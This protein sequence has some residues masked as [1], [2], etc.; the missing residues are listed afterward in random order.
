MA[1]GLAEVDKV[2]ELQLVVMGVMTGV[3]LALLL[4]TTATAPEFRAMDGT[5]VI[6]SPVFTAPQKPR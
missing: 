3:L 4:V 2:S 5:I 6:D 1:V